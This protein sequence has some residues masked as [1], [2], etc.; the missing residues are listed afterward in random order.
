[1][2]T[3][4]FQITTEKREGEDSVRANLQVVEINRGGVDMLV[5][6]TPVLLNCC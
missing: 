4:A 1:M 3:S 6:G 5:A 2:L